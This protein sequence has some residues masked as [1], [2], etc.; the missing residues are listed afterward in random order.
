[1]YTRFVL[2]GDRYCVAYSFFHNL[3]CLPPRR[4]RRR[5]RRICVAGTVHRHV[6]GKTPSN[7]LIPSLL[8]IL[9]DSSSSLA[10][11]LNPSPIDLGSIWC[12]QGFVNYKRCNFDSYPFCY[13]FFLWESASFCGFMYLICH[14]QFSLLICPVKL[15]SQPSDWFCRLIT[16]IPQPPSVLGLMVRHAFLYVLVFFTF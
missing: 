9:F 8:I 1:M 13:F 12:I 3:E 7:N 10:T 6:S 2:F 16:E 5:R 15:E 14:V 11:L 4:I